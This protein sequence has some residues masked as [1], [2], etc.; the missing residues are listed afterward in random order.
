M[1]EHLFF[2]CVCECLGVQFFNSLT[3][4]LQDAMPHQR[5]LTLLPRKAEDF[6]RGNRHFKHASPPTY[7]ICLSPKELY[8]VG[9]I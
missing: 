8:T 9:S 7:L 4:D 6:P 3:C 1:T 2:L 5:S